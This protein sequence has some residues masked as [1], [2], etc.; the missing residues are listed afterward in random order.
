ML[1]GDLNGSLGA[2]FMWLQHSTHLYQEGIDAAVEAVNDSAA[3]Q[4]FVID[5]GKDPVFDVA[6][7]DA[8][9][10]H[11]W[12]RVLAAGHKMAYECGVSAAGATTEH[13]RRQASNTCLEAGFSGM[14]RAASKARDCRVSACEAFLPK[15][16]RKKDES[17]TDAANAAA[18]SFQAISA[19]SCAP[20]DGSMDDALAQAVAAATAK[21]SAVAGHGEAHEIR[22]LDGKF[23]ARPGAANAALD[24]D[25]LARVAACLVGLA[26]VAATVTAVSLRR[27]RQYDRLVDHVNV[28]SVTLL[29]GAE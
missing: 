11:V 22:Y 2:N 13:A 9:D 14:L 12:D 29:P 1:L 25:S 3:D 18:Q 20:A 26:A 15:H 8:T 27:R 6:C 4:A 16:S 21:G 24:G 10:D 5:E 28:R 7:N 17:L 19:A 23:L